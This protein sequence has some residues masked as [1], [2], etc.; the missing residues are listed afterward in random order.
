[1]NFLVDVKFNEFLVKVIWQKN[2]HFVIIMLFIW[3]HLNCVI[4]V[5]Q[6]FTY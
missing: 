2:D 3:L 6:L 4:N 1:M 5:F